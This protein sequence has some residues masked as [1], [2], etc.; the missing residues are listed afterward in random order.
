MFFKLKSNVLF[1]DYGSFGYI[2]DNR[3]FGYKHTDSPDYVGD[4]I[5]SE[6]GAI[7]LSVMGRKINT[8]DELAEKILTRFSGVDISVI[9]DDARELY[10]A[11]E[12][13]GFIVSG[14]TLRECEEK[15]I[16]FSYR[17]TT[18]QLMNVGDSS[19]VIRPNKSTQDFFEEHFKGKP[20]LT[21]L[22]IEIISRCN[23]RCVHCYI[24]HDY[25]I[26]EIVPDLFYNILNQCRAMNLL[27][28]TISGG[29][30]MLHKH[31]VDFIRKCKE[32]DFSLNILSNL[33]LLNDEIIGAMKENPLLGV[34][35]SVYSM[36]PDIHDDIT[37]MKG[38]L[39]KT[40]DA[41]LRLIDN[42]IPLQIS[43][44]IMKQNKTCYSD[45]VEWANEHNIYA[46]DD[47]A[48]IA[49]YNNTTQNLNC[50][51]SIDEIKDVIEDKVANDAKYL[52]RL[53]EE[54]ERKK[55]ATS[56]DFVCSVCN[57]SICISDDGNVY[58]C[59]GWQGYSVGNMKDTSLNYIW[60]NSEKVQYLR[61]LRN[62]D[63]PKCL[64]CPDKEFCTICMVRNANESPVGDIFAV[65][66]HF[67]SI[68]K[69]NKEFCLNN[70]PNT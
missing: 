40:K 17:N 44:P 1:R 7:F 6:T 46:G 49:R 14:R 5:L 56:D 45:V 35:T 26:S 4:K 12:N 25:K 34:Q 55:Q 11:L 48:L 32:Y 16:R 42:D 54:A 50:R 8:L 33:T 18:P 53:V 69:L 68:A 29:E 58:P 51:L 9:K 2:T 19:M 70:M 15:D 59:A 65:N 47:F 13:D 30:P 39:E 23:E 3:N 10:S 37:Q 57:S 24:P 61:E 67:C 20:Q 28:I 27:H 31:F 36:N 66:E 52:S 62:S 21:S 38:S 60:N 22:H 64:Q 41:I 63:F 43:C